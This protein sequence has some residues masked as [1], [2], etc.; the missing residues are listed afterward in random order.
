MS[1]TGIAG[2]QMSVPRLTKNNYENWSIQMKALLGSQEA[3]KIIERGFAEPENTT[4]Y[5][6]AQTKTLKDNRKF[7][8]IA[9]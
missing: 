7:D 6:A 5:T 1:T 4:G 9:L 2:G 3:W 8:K